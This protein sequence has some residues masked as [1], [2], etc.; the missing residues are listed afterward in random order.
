MRFGVPLRV[1]RDS[2]CTLVRG[3]ALSVRTGKSLTQRLIQCFALVGL[4]WVPVV[5]FAQV[6]FINEVHYDNAS[7]DTQEAVE[8][9]GRAGTSLSGWSLLLY[10][11]NG[12]AVYATYP[13]SGTIPNLCANFGTVAIATPGIQNGSPDGVA[14]VNDLGEVVEFLSY[15]GVF[16]ATD[17]PAAGLTSI[18][19]GVAE[20]GTGP[21]TS[22]L[23]RIG[24]GTVGSDFGW[25]EATSSFG[26]C[27]GG[28]TFVGGIDLPPDVLS[29]TPAAG[30]TGVSPFDDLEIRFSEDVSVASGWASLT[31]SSSGTVGFS[32]TGGPRNFVLNP[33]PVLVPG[34]SCTV[35]IL[36]TAVT[37][38]D[39][40]ANA[41]AQDLAFAFQVAPD[42]APAVAS[43]VPSDGAILVRI[44]TNVVVTFSEPVTVGSGAFALSCITTGPIGLT[45]AGGPRTYTLDPVADLPFEDTCSLNVLAAG[46]LDQDGTP[47]APS[48][49]SAISWTNEQ[50]LATYYAAVDNS[51]ALAL[52]TTLHGV[53][54]DHIRYPYTASTTDT[55]DILNLADE[56]PMDPNR[57][58]DVYKNASYPKASGG[59]ANYNREHR[60][61]KSYGFPDDLA[62][63]WAYTDAHHLIVSNSG[64]NSARNNRYFDWC[65]DGCTEYPTDATNGIGGGSGTYPGNSNWGRGDRWEVWG[66]RKGDVARAL[67]YMDVR[68]EGGTNGFG[69]PEPDLVLTNNPALI[70]TTGSNTTGQ[71][72]LGLLC[73]LVDWHRLDPPDEGERLR[74]TLVQSFQQNRN[75]F[76]D[77]PEWADVLFSSSCP[78][79]DVG[80][81]DGFE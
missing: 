19:I 81:R 47:D 9:A 72:F 59:N 34:E 39:P 42:L 22:S 68:Y 76:V 37:D 60:W 15:E 21:A 44:S 54:D 17:G 48:G 64:Y 66:Y 73:V 18:D 45:V 14:V 16:T 2:S 67:L 40:P 63:S 77:R 61:A 25:T 24:T 58:L 62:S 74:N 75:P 33:A 23:Q 52:R 69:A 3:S 5:A 13:L 6:V 46:I 78:L 53:I 41:M 79:P 55:W 51:S 28:Q 35:S 31:C 36:G 8:I 20:S 11:G 10:N 1:K 4:A 43:T 38:L 80:F 30:A 71:A 32:E 65:A 56:D 49:D 7:T 26:G 50:S 29:T 12:G 70:Q 57:V 27:N